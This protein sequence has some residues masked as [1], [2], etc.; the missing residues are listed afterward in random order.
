MPIMATIIVKSEPIRWDHTPKSTKLEDHL[1][2]IYR[3][4]AKI[5]DRYEPEDCGLTV[6][7]EQ[8]AAQSRCDDTPMLRDTDRRHLPECYK[9]GTVFS[10]PLEGHVPDGWAKIHPKFVV[11]GVSPD[12]KSCTALPV[13]YFIDYHYGREACDNQY[14]SLQD[15]AKSDDPG[16]WPPVSKHG[17]IYCERDPFLVLSGRKDEPWLPQ[18]HGIHFRDPTTHLFTEV[19]TIEGKV[20]EEGYKKLMQLGRELKL[21]WGE[22]LQDEPKGLQAG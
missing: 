19:A 16:Q 2:S 7:P 22:A 12:G 10:T 9:P 1:N 18:N 8:A 3:D 20:T 5:N 15:V 11:V 6:A 21:E 14:V 17:I 4:I 13:K